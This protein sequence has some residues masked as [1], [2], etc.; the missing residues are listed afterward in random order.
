MHIPF[1]SIPEDSRIWIF[2][3]SRKFYPQELKSIHTSVEDFLTIWK[4]NDSPIEASFQIK[5]DRFIII[6]TT[7]TKNALNLEAHDALS[8]FIQKL[9]KTFSVTLIDKINVCFKQGEYVQYKELVAFKKLIKTRSVSKNT[10]VFDNMISTKG[11]LKEDW[12]I[13]LSES[14]LSYLL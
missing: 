7:E 1:D 6:A 10:I 11:M 8:H 9:E 13:Y 3:S 12:E 14:W 5:Y 2:P 4:S